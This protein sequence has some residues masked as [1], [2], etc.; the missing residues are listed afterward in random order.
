MRS[1]LSRTWL[2]LISVVLLTACLVL[3]CAA[4]AQPQDSQMQQD[5]SI[6]D[7]SRRSRE[8]KKIAKRQSRVITN[9]DMD[10]EYFKPGQEG[11]KLN[12]E[13]P[14]AG[15][16]AITEAAD[17][18]A[19]SANKES[20]PKGKNSE[21]TAAED[22]EIAKLK[23]LIAEAEED[24]NLQQRELALDE[25][26]VYSNPNYTDSKTGKAKLDS[27]RQRINEKQQ[28][29]EGLKAH[30]AALQ[31]RRTHTVPAESVP[32]GR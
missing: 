7:A 27:E 21:E 30:L 8:Q 1:R 26:T 13:A 6:A 14:S 10:M 28:E 15:A 9:D 25:D 20:R 11:L 12:T 24:L 2:M 5:Q 18:A 17:Q 3:P 29:I 32:P 4:G 31:E 19:T 23:K 22:V 16:V